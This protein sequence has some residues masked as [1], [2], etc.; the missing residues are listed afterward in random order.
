MPTPETIAARLRHIRQQQNL[1]LKQVEIKSRGR[2]K[3]VVIGSYER[4]TRSLSIH[5]AQ[6]ICDFYGVPLVALFK[7]TSQ[8]INQDHEIRLVL[9]LRKLRSIERGADNFTQQI[10]NF[11]QWIAEHRD[12]WNGEVL[13]I[14]KSDGQILAIMTHKHPEELL[15]ALKNRN[16]LL[17]N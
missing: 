10:Y 9:D 16:L 12:D 14:R 13:S 4:G 8:E 5:R 7:E 1:T 17:K 2:W 3:A 6:E 11:L 15:D